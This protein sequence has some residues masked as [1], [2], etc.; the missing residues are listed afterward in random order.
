MRLE[1]L[2]LAAA[3]LRSRLH[4]WLILQGFD[5]KQT[6]FLQNLDATKDE[7]NPTW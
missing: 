6:N 2:E 1:K 3:R 4:A 7:S 5:V